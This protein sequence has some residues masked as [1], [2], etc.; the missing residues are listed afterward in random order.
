MA[1]RRFDNLLELRRHKLPNIDINLTEG[2]GLGA[3]LPKTNTTLLGN[4]QY[5]EFHLAGYGIFEYFFIQSELNG[6]YINMPYIRTTMYKSDRA[7]EHF[8]FAQLNFLIGA[9]FKL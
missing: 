6:G 9:N 3:L 1:V 8:L 2:F 5:D 4:A 7:A